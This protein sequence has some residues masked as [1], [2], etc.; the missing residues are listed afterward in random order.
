MIDTIYVE[1]DVGD[2]PRT[3]ELLRRFPEA[4]RVAIGR[5][6]EVFNRRAQSFRLQKRRPSLILARKHHGL[7]LETPAGYGVGAGSNYYFSH[8]LNCVFDCRYCFLQGMFQSAHYVIFVNFEDFE[9]AI[10]AKLGAGDESACFFSGYDCDSLAF[11]AWTGFGAHFVDW[12]SRLPRSASL[13]LRTKSLQA[14]VLLER[15]PLPNVIVAFSLT[16]REVSAVHEHKVPP[17]AKRLALMGDLAR[18]GWPIGL[19]LDPLIYSDGYRNAYRNLL[20][21]VR[22]V[23]ASSPV[24]SVSLGALRF[25]RAMFDAI[26]RQYPEEPLLAVPEITGAGIVSYP[27][28]VERTMIDFCREQLST[29]VPTERIFVCAPSASS[30][31]VGSP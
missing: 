26:V 6:G 7:V 8:M 30:E 20:H 29:W 25:P 2:H 28:D 12:F 9:A 23:L 27:L 4:T 14:R 1:D 31:T 3:V 21:D 15:E 24:H 5:Y 16:P 17:L 19:R 10:T 22:A 11:E 18:R 13:E